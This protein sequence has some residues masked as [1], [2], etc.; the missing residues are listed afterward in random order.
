MSHT[1]S[2]FGI[3]TERDLSRVN[4]FNTDTLTLQ[5]QIN[6]DVDAI[7]VDINPGVTRAV[8]TS[9]EDETIVQL[10]LTTEPPSIIDSEVLDSG[11]LNS[12]AITTFSTGQ[13][14]ITVREPESLDREIV[15]YNLNTGAIADTLQ[16]GV[17]VAYPTDPIHPGDPIAPVVGVDT[18]TALIRFFTIDNT[19]NLANTAFTPLASGG[20]SPEYIA[21]TNNNNYALVSNFGGNNVTAV[22]LNNGGQPVITDT[23]STTANP[24]GIAVTANDQ[25]AFVLTATSVDRF[26]FNT[27]TGVLTFLDSFAHGL[28][29]PHYR[30]IAQI[31]LDATE[32]KLF[33]SGTLAGNDVLAA[34]TTTGA[35]LGV[36]AG[37]QANGGVVTAAFPKPTRGISL[38]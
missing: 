28:T 26:S 11:T 37:I 33:I 8:V 4:F 17:T 38:W 25:L 2:N 13:F 19:G 23:K 27:N 16:A 35:Q 34:F 18:A 3:V 30:G 24:M 29:I 7:D 12:V 10:D 14:A 9:A 20:A 5:H 15:S 36:I 22:F 6:V 31:A 32:T 1:N 21:I